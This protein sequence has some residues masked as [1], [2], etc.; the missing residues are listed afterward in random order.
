MTANAPS[1]ASNELAL[2]S[3]WASKVEPKL[4]ND[5]KIQAWLEIDLDNRLQFSA[6][7]VLVTNR[8]LLAFAPGNNNGE[9]YPLPGRSARHQ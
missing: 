7:L 6:G 4:A 9:E 3:H 5:E 1:P 8:R 2:P